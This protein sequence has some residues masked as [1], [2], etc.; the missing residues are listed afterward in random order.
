[1]DCPRCE[2]ELASGAYESHAAFYC[3]QCTGVLFEQAALGKTLERLSADLFSA[4][5]VDL[6]IPALPDIKGEAH[7]PKCQAKMEN[8]GYMGTKRVMLDACNRCAV[9]WVDPM[10]LATMAQMRARLDKNMEKF[11]SAHR[12]SDIVGNQ[13]NIRM[14]EQA[15]LAGMIFG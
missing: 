3:T 14:V 12:P 7:C 9:I 15:F 10:E 2:N 6:P 5:S 11:R 4:I 1:M 13:I 8:Y